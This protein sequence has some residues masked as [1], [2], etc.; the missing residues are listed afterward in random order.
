M[1]IPLF[2]IPYHPKSYLDAKYHRIFQNLFLRP[3]L[4]TYFWQMIKT[5]PQYIWTLLSLLVGITLGG[6]FPEALT[7]IG[8]ETASFLKG[9]I[10]IVPVLIFFALSPAIA[11]LVKNRSGG[12]LATYVMIWYIGTSIVAGLLGILISSFLFEMTPSTGEGS[13]Q[14]VLNMF[15]ILNGEGGASLPLLSILIAIIT[16][17]VAIKIAPLNTFL[18][19]VQTTIN[20]SAS[21]LGYIMIPLIFCLGIT[22]GIKSGARESF[23]YYLLMSGYTFLLCFI[24]WIFYLLVIIK[25]IA[26]QPLHKVITTYYLPT[27]IF[28]AGTCS[29]LV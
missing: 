15:S 26:K 8:K 21:Y 29:S 13:F 18:Q 24:W 7:F 12:K 20:Q 6:F 22:L 11:S 1:I 2:L 23:Q 5:I 14:A 27:A 28:A 9:F 4:F 17:L 3:Y 25:G 16:G 19:K 10:T